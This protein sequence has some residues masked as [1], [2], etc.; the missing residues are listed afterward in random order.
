MEINDLREL[1]RLRFPRRPFRQ[2]LQDDLPSKRLKAGMREFR[3][4]AWPFFIFFRKLV[5]VT[6]VACRV[7]A[8]AK[9]DQLS[10]FPICLSFFQRTVA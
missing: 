3:A 9:A 1:D 4:V 5:Q 7:E 2:D 6:S 10:I 8:L